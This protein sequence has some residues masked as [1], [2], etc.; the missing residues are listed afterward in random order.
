MK[1]TKELLA[2]F[3]ATRYEVDLPARRVQLQVD[4]PCEALRQWMQAEGHLCAAL[5]TAH[6]PGARRCDPAANH[7]AQQ[8]LHCVLQEH[9]L[10]FR[11]GCN[12]DPQQHWPE[13]DSVLVAGLPL[14]QAM[15]LAVQFGQLA[16]LWCD[17][18]GV[19]QLH[20][21]TPD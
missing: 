8:R 10:A 1:L 13:E 6:N 5:I 21:A 12:R 20:L 9:G 16:I 11:S 7:A 17:T 4:T 2:A 14:A 18:S 3:R 19:P 15:R